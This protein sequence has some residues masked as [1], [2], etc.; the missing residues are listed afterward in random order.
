[1]K[2]DW[3]KIVGNAI[4]TLV[5]AIVAGACLI[6]WRGVM[7][8]DTRINKAT[9]ALKEQAEYMKQAVEVIQ[10]E[11]VLVKNQN[12]ELLASYRKSKYHTRSVDG[13]ED[14]ENGDIEL[15]EERTAPDFIQRRLP[16]LDVGQM[17]K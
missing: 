17:A 3:G 11:L 8:I 6:V 7:T 14:M 12:R 9:T 4:S 16:K 5:A 10:E 13:I 15:P 1:M 2:I